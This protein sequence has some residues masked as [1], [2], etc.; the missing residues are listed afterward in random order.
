MC[1]M[2]EKRLIIDLKICG[3]FHLVFPVKQYHP[4]EG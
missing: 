1:L 2:D 3:L 4:R